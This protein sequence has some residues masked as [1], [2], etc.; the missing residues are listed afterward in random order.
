MSW[1]KN[2]ILDLLA[3]SGFVDGF[4]LFGAMSPHIMWWFNPFMG[5]LYLMTLPFAGAMVV[6][7]GEKKAN[8][9]E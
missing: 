8:T 4:L 3:L 9:K 1:K 7:F 5:M 6:L 2:L